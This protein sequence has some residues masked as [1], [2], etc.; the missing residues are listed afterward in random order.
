MIKRMLLLLMAAAAVGL[1]GC[2]STPAS[3]PRQDAAASS[4]AAQVQPGPTGHKTLI[5]Y[6]SYTGHTRTLA[7]HIHELIGGDIVEL[8]VRTPYPDDYQTVVAQ[9]KREV[10]EGVKP[11]LTTKIDNFEQYDTVLIGTPIWWYHMSPAVASFM[12]QHD[13]SGKTVVPFCTHGGYE[14][15]CIQDMMNA[16]PG[17]VIGPSFSVNGNEVNESGTRIRT[18]LQKADLLPAKGGL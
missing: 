6:F 10:E 9:G 11:E 17:A 8:Q 5:V 7:Q 18:W 15:T 2:G 12:S 1:M 3:S 14:G 4:Q 16:A 13:F